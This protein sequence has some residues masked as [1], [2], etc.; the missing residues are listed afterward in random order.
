M[1]P[2]DVHPLPWK[3]VCEREAQFDRKTGA[4]IAP[5]VW[6]YIHDALGNLVLI[7]TDGIGAAE[8]LR[9]IIEAVNEK[10]GG[11]NAETKP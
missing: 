9:T 6:H 8:L 10:H 2:F 3:Y 1:S 7:K 11:P 4:A 5:S